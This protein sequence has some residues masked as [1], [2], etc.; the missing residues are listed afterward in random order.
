MSLDELRIDESVFS[1][2]V[3]AHDQ[4]FESESSPGVTTNVFSGEIVTPSFG[5]PTSIKFAVRL[6]FG[7]ITTIFEKMRDRVMLPFPCV[8]SDVPIYGGNSGGPVFD[9]RGRICAINCTSF[10]GH[11]IAFHIPVR[12]VLHLRT[13][14]ESLGIKVPSRKQRSVLEL[15]ASEMILFDPPMLDADRIAHSIL[16]WL[17]YAAKCLMRREMP[18]TNVHFA[19]AMDEP[20]APTGNS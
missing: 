11:E 20:T 16:R 13:R 18:S 17:W 5:E 9:V 4:L 14:A 1:F 15:A 8:Q 19:K 7:K 2:A 10:G 12:G 6:S 3:V